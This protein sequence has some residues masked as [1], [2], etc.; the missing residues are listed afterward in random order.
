MT[1]VY[2]SIGSNVEREYNVRSALAALR[3]RYAPLTVSPIYETGAVGFDGADFLNL[4]VGF[5]THL[6]P[7]TLTAEFKAL[8]DAHGRERGG[9][10]GISPRTLDLDLL[11]WGDT[12]YD[13]GRVRLPRAE[14]VDCAFVLRP[15]ADIAGDEPHPTLGRPYA[16]LWAAFDASGQPM[17]RIELD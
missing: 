4:V 7:A 8:E 5:D 14:I 16:E 6:D 11:T 15:L 17:R 12:A 1:R 2:V 3:A 10:G 9:H 13:D